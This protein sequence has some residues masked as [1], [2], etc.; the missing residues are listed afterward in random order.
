MNKPESVLENNMH[1][2]I[3]DFQ[4]QVCYFMLV[5]RPGLVIF[6]Q[7]RERT[8]EGTLASHRITEPKDRQILRACLRHK[9]V[10]EYEK[11]Y[12][13]NC[14]WRTQITYHWLEKE[15][16]R[17]GNRL[18]NR[19]YPNYSIVETVRILRRVLETWDDMV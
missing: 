4:I 18:S 10:V 3:W 1:K 16:E 9:T 11:D 17:I 19:D 12:E 8:V 13:I 14:N 6:N 7:K 2:I 5:R 15:T